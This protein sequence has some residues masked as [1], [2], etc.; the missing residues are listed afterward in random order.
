MTTA[1]PGEKWKLLTFNFEYINENRI[2]VSNF[3]RIRTF[4]KTSDGKIL[5]GSMI[6]GYRIIR[7]KFFKPRDPGVAQKLSFLQEQVRLLAQKIKGMKIEKE[8][9]VEFEDAKKLL[10]T[11]KKNLK[12]KFA[13]DTKK[14]TIH[15]HALIHRL[16]ADYFLLKPTE[17]QTIVAH[18]DHDKL[19]N[20]VAN[21]RWMTPDTNYAHQQL[22]PYVIAER[23]DRKTNP[24][25]KPSHSKLTVTR[26]MLL[27]KLLNE[28]RP[29]KSLAKQFK[30]TNT[31]ILRIKR[32]ENWAQIQAAN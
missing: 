12:K 16:V 21:I 31:Q 28:G 19:N 4:N 32:G 30:I 7:L 18:V 22:S 29:I 25:K 14:R 24:L 11:V 27:K 2:E 6:N 5:K 8:G 15:Y 20:N 26:V 3:G 13:E 10:A 23:L 1:H 9:T 17:G